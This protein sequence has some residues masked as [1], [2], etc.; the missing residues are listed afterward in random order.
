[1]YLYLSL[2]KTNHHISI[3]IIFLQSTQNCKKKLISILFKFYFRSFLKNT[4]SLE[5]NKQDTK[6]FVTIFLGKHLNINVTLEE[7]I[8][9]SIKS[10][11]SAFGSFVYSSNI[12]SSNL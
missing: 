5:K 4:K 12:H 7:Y 8:N 3:L 9:K 11:T 2:T 6:M 1:M 10:E